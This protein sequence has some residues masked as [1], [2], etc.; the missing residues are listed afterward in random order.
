MANCWIH[1][2]VVMPCWHCSYIKCLCLISMRYA[3]LLKYAH[4]V[5]LRTENVLGIQILKHL[6]VIM[7]TGCCCE[8]GINHDGHKVKGVN[9]DITFPR[10]LKQVQTWTLRSMCLLLAGSSRPCPQG[11]TKYKICVLG[12]GKNLGLSSHSS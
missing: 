1:F 2:L 10:Q 11:H 6:S 7:V 8:I 4:A 12:K 3:A 9:Q 5:D